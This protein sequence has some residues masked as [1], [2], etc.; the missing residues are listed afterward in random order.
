MRNQNSK[1]DLIPNKTK[2]IIDSEYDK[3]EKT[4][5]LKLKV[6]DIK[7]CFNCSIWFVII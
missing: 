1:K 6:D 7:K 2:T 4:S 5:L 3:H